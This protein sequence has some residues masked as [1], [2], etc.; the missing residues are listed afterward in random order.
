MER[1]MKRK[2]HVRCEAGGKLG[3]NIKELPIAIAWQL[4]GNLTRY[5]TGNQDS[6]SH[7]WRQ[8]QRTT[9]PVCDYEANKRR[10]KSG[11]WHF[12]IPYGYF[13]PWRWEV[14]CIKACNPFCYPEQKKE[15][16]SVSLMNSAKMV[17]S[18]Q[19]ISQ[20]ILRAWRTMILHTCYSRTVMWNNPSVRPTA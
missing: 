1:R 5:C 17:H 10:W 11:D 14:P 13:L 6:Q 16:C 19:R 9:W 3:D 7:Q 12:D 15:D 2:F 18:W 8:K 20:T 4:A